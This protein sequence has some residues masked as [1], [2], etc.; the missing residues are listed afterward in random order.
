MDRN[1]LIESLRTT[2]LWENIYHHIESIDQAN[3]LLQKG[4]LENDVDVENV[5]IQDS[6]DFYITAINAE[7]R[8]IVVTFE[9]PFILC[10]NKKYS[11]QAVATGSLDIP[12][13][14]DY[15]YDRY[16]FLSMGKK[17]LLSFGNIIS[18]SEIAYEDVELL[19]VW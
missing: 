2:L 10:V 14:E 7:N 6:E 19:G 11:I 17:E 5:S 18:I 15:P 12:N 1:T 4:R 9:M 13:T 16:D 3:I 8:R